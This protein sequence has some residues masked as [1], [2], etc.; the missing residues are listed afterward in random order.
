MGQII[1]PNSLL[2]RTD[3]QPATVAF[4]NNLI[5]QLCLAMNGVGTRM[6]GYDAAV[7]NLVSL[8]LANI[9]STLGPFLTTLQQAASLGF[10]VGE[11]D[12][13]LNALTVG[14]QFDLALTNSGAS[15]FTPT[16][17][18]TML[19][20]N[21]STNWGVCQ[22]LS[23]IPQNANLS[24]M[25]IYC[26]KTKQ[27]PSWQVAC[28]SG[29]M[30]ASVNAMTSANTSA[31]NAATSASN[32]AA[33]AASVAGLAGAIAAGPVVSVAGRSGAIVLAEADVANLVSDL[34]ARPLTSFVTAQLATKQNVSA[35]L[36]ALAALTYSSFM[37]AFLGAID[38]PTAR[39]TL[40]LNDAATHPASDF[41]TP[42]AIAA[43]PLNA[44]Q[45][46]A[47]NAAI[48]AATALPAAVINSNQITAGFNDQVGTSY[49]MLASDYGKALTF[50]NAGA[51]TVT[52]PNSLPK[53]WNVIVYQGGAGQ[54]TFN[55]ASG[56]SMAQR[57]AK[58]R[59]AGQYALV[60][61]MVMANTSGTNALYVLG[62]DVA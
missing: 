26:T 44:T 59:T 18:L 21:D 6:D 49:T 13:Q 4:L 23:W 51:I 40:G 33:S 56:A 30:D 41:A 37:I 43:A 11:A 47:V 58:N 27:S 3:K 35:T 29:V 25:C 61:L 54:V 9:N 22:L 36:N 53:G 48:A 8:G 1:D 28:G 16:K 5:T 14:Q 19:D 17:W 32:A 52:L 10:L 12:G 15:L 34:A 24:T 60:T 31:T 57:L 38:A 45:T 39:S 20:V 50:T 2:I 55:P 42:A 7:Q 62:G 46:T